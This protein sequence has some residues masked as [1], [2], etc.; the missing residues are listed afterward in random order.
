MYAYFKLFNSIKDE[1]EVELARLELESLVGPVEVVRNFSDE[2]MKKPLK[3]LIDSVQVTERGDESDTVRFQDFV[4]HE[5]AYGKVHGFVNRRFK[6]G[7]IKP[8][9][10]K[11]GYTR[12]IYVVE[13]RKSWQRFQRTVFPDGSIRKNC[14][15]FFAKEF[16]AVRAITN[17]YFLENCDYVLKITPS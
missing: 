12:E 13:E 5:V 4:M 10:R 16:A 8:L 9:V 17:Q 2:L 15:V 7:D 3:A 14:N 1:H 11:L 6:F